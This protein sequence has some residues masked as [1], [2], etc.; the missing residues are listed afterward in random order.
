MCETKEER[1]KGRKGE[2]LP[3]QDQDGKGEDIHQQDQGRRER[4]R[5]LLQHVTMEERRTHL[6]SRTRVKGRKGEFLPDQ[7]Q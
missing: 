5:E 3:K 1:K 6:S 4:K 2:L 7:D